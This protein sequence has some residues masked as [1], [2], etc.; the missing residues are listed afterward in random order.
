MEKNNKYILIVFITIL[1]FSILILVNFMILPNFTNNTD[2]GERT[3][4]SEVY[5]ITLKIDYSGEKANEVFYDINL[6][7]YQT[8][9]YDALVKLI[10]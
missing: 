10:L 6:T 7:N 5:N 2:S 3:K 8:T 1:S 9:V 4:L